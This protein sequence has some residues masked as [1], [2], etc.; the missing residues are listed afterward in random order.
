MMYYNNQFKL[1]NKKVLSENCKTKFTIIN[2]I[3]FNNIEEHNH[4]INHNI[5]LIK[6]VKYKFFKIKKL[7]NLI[8]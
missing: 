6:N 2:K 3:Y 4:L 8:N 7:S 5:I 1:I